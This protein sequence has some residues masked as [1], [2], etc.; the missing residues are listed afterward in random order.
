MRIFGNVRWFKLVCAIVL[1]SVA[2]Y[3]VASVTATIF[4]CTP[5]AK[6]FDK[7]IEG[8]CIDNGRFW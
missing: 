1:G 3:C 2:V 8:Y 5:I 7:T 4:Q 6:A